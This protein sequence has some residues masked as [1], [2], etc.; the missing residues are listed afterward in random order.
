MI[1]QNILLKKESPIRNTNQYFFIITLLTLII[2]VL[3]LFYLIKLKFINDF[4]PFN[5]VIISIDA[6][7]ADHMGVYGYLKDT[8]PNIDK[9][10]KGAFVFINAVTTIPQTYPSFATLMT[11]Q[12]PLTT[13]VFSNIRSDGIGTPLDDKFVTLAEVLKKNKYF[14]A[15]FVFNQALEKKI[16]HLDQ[17]FDIYDLNKSYGYAGNYF[18]PEYNRIYK[19]T[20]KFLENNKNKKFFLWVHLMDPHTPYAPPD[21]KACKFNQKYCPAILSK[22]WQER[23]AAMKQIWWCQEEDLPDDTVDLYK[24]LYDGEINQSDDVFQYIIDKLKSLKLEN[25][26]IVILYAD[27]GE[28]FEH[29]YYFDHGSVLNHSAVNIPLIIKHPIIKPKNKSDNHLIEN[30]DIYPTI[31]DLLHI[32]FPKNTIDGN[33]FSSIFTPNI[34]PQKKRENSFL[35]DAQMTKFGIYDGRYKFILSVKDRAC[36]YKNQ[37]EELYDLK[38]DPFEIKSLISSQNGLAAKYKK[39][40]LDYLAKYNPIKIREEKSIKS[41][42]DKSHLEE[43]K[44]LGY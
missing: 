4:Q 11:G 10:S 33:S 19:D 24:T 34:I 1:I 35:I 20:D 26:T 15:A 17:G 9:W 39:L 12:H 31:L 37:T 21:D 30:S 40:I 22:D 36:L 7:R 27:H 6:L 25:K 32:S 18:N 16:T 28:S 2:F 41:D 42:I 3:G 43:L 13:A 5:L 23:D 14:T 29:D 44:S 8:T 38:E